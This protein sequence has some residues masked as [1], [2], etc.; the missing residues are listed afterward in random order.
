MELQELTPMAGL[1][2]VYTNITVH[3]HKR[4]FSETLINW[5]SFWIELTKSG[6]CLLFYED[7][8]K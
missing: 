8:L 6:G 4:M 1:L 7:L 3:L 2:V 5:M